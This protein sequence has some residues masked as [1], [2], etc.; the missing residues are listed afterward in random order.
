MIVKTKRK[1]TSQAGDNDAISP[2]NTIIQKKH[3]GGR[4]E[5]CEKRHLSPP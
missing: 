2:A 1:N 4:R 5:I 3:T